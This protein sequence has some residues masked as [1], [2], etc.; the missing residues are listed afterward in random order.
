MS[1]RVFVD[2]NVLVYAHDA[3]AGAKHDVAKEA[4]AEIWAERCGVLSTQVLEEFYSAV[5]RKISRRLR[6]G[7][8][9]EALRAYAAW[10]VQVISVAT[11][12]EAARLAE[13]HRLALWDGLIVAAAVEAGAETILTE[14]F[15]D[16]ARI[17]GVAVRSPFGGRQQRGR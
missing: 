9:L 15:Q 16:G 2:A 7:D 3:D 6:H 4:L 10:D 11:V 1:A 14:D 12:L 13:R 5:T 8:A 17:A